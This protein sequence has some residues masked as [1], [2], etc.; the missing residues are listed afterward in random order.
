LSE[1]SAAGEAGAAP[2]A[3]VVIPTRRRET[4]LAFALEALAAQTLAPER[5]EVVVVRAPDAAGGPLARPP[6]G[7]RVRFLTSAVAAPAAQRNLGWRSTAA[8]LVAFTDDDCRP[9]PRWLESLLAAAGGPSTILQGRTQPD[10]DERHLWWGLARSWEIT[11][12]N[13][14]FATCNIAYPR[15]LLERLGGFDERF[16]AAWGED[17]D[18]G[19]RARELGARVRYVD[20][21]VVWHAVVSR[22]LRTALRE[23]SRHDA[24]PVVVKRHRIHRRNLL[25]GVGDHWHVRWLLLVWG[26]ASLRRRPLTGALATI[27]YLL[28]RVNWRRPL[29]LRTVRQL[30]HLPVA[31][32]LDGVETLVTLRSA[33]RN[34]VLVL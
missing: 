12:P 4:R 7:L 5:F 10:P 1:G 6:A 26:L 22:P 11:A 8:P 13:L 25:A 3:C 27:P 31:F 19:L 33:V 21:A 32:T 9:A 23:A 24:M 34:R 2:E 30:A 18:L 29:T 20:D 16:P 14:W 15:A 17:T 28:P